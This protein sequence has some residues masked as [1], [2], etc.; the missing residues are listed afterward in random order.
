M[1][2]FLF[3]T[4][5]DIVVRCS[6]IIDDFMNNPS[7]STALKTQNLLQSRYL[8]KKIEEAEVASNS[9]R[10]RLARGASL[11]KGKEETS[12]DLPVTKIPASILH[13]PSTHSDG[14]AHKVRFEDSSSPQPE[15][16]QKDLPALKKT[17]YVPVPMSPKKQRRS[18]IT[19]EVE[20]V[21]YG[22]HFNK[23]HVIV[24]EVTLAKEESSAGFW[25]RRNITAPDRAAAEK[26]YN[27]A[28]SGQME[29]AV[30]NEPVLE[31]QVRR[32]Y[33]F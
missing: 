4:F 15:D 9:I 26:A 28:S 6:V 17:G 25:E 2:D 7:V 32:C 27:S 33:Y 12:S 31:T 16:S 10:S 23:Y 14:A 19:G 11:K 1:F 21:F 20:Y 18:F 8:K 22:M 5:Q 30:N 29:P 13:D 3:S 24:A